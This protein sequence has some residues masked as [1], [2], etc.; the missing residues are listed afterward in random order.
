MEKVN[1]IN[2]TDKRNVFS[3]E[4][5][6]RARAAALLTGYL[7]MDPY[8]DVNWG[9]L[10][11]GTDRIT[12]DCL[13]PLVG[14]RLKSQ[15]IKLPVY[16]TLEH[17]LHADNLPSLLPALKKRYPSHHFLAVDAALGPR[18]HLGEVLIK[19][20][21]LQPGKGLKKSLPCVGDISITGIIGEEDSIPELILPYTRL[22]LVDKL[23]EFISRC[24]TESISAI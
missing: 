15:G 5:N 2:M 24:I 20:S 18:Q 19:P 13:G 10:C 22:Y 23:A 9:I 21:P 7:T 4:K 8:K 17:P 12:G 6:N 14:S 3:A 1:E 11:I 16:G